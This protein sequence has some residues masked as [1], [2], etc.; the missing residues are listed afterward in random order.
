MDGHGDDRCSGWSGLKIDGEDQI[1]GSGHGDDQ[2]RGWDRGAVG[3]HGED[4]C[5]GWDRGAV[6]MA[7]GM[8]M[9]DVWGG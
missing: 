9:T 3:G 7:M 1:E 5:R 6:A 4:R 2:C 8:G